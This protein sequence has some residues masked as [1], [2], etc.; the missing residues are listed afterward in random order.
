[1][2]ARLPIIFLAPLLLISVVTLRAADPS[3]RN[4]EWR[5]YGGDDAGTKYSALGQINRTNVHQLKPAWIYRCD[6]MRERPATTI[7]CNPLII[8]GVMFSTTARL[9]VVALNAATGAQRWMFDP[10]NGSG[11]GGVNRGVTYWASGEDKRIFMVAS[12]R[13]D[14]YGSR[15]YCSPTLDSW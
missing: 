3:R 13:R 5:V 8:D 4:S 6:D 10:W 14:S 2:R 1:M 15:R 11:G 12:L 9:K 7:E